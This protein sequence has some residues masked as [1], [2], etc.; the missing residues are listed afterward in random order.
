MSISSFYKN[1]II[2]VLGG[3]G[4]IGSEIVT[5]LLKYEPKTIRI[6]SNS[7]NELWETRLKLI[8][9]VVNMFQRHKWLYQK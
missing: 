5:H 8:Q 2:V 9:L 3:T 4:S 7:E 6:L 1:K